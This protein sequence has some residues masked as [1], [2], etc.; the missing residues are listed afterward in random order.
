[1]H[2]SQ[3]CAA[4]HPLTDAISSLI[5]D[6]RI[7]RSQIHETSI[8]CS[9]RKGKVPTC[10]VIYLWVVVRCVAVLNHQ[11]D[12]SV[13]NP[14]VS[15][16]IQSVAHHGQSLGTSRCTGAECATDSSSGNQSRQHDEGGLKT[17]LDSSRVNL[18]VTFL[19]QVSKIVSHIYK[20]RAWR[21]DL[22]R[23][24]MRPQITSIVST[25]H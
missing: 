6:R 9:K 22:K 16:E 20:Y 3:L 21:R 7:G 24:T 13:R 12:M 5:D 8:S 10:F 25:S 2:D 1:M 14:R 19:N 11:C 18:L 4:S 17:K 23:H 15:I